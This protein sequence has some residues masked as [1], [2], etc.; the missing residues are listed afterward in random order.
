MHR[1]LSPRSV[2]QRRDLSKVEGHCHTQS[3]AGVVQSR[4]KVF[5]PVQK[6]TEKALG[7]SLSG[8]VG[9]DGIFIPPVP[10]ELMQGLPNCYSYWPLCAGHVDWTTFVDFTNVAAAGEQLGW[11]KLFYGP[12]SLLEEF[13]DTKCS[14]QAV[15]SCHGPLQR[16]VTARYGTTVPQNL[17]ASDAVSWRIR[18]TRLE[19]YS[20]REKSLQRDFASSRCEK[21]SRGGL[22]PYGDEDLSVLYW[23][24][25]H[26]RSGA[27]F[28]DWYLDYSRPRTGPS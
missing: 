16:R 10:G 7:H 4:F 25:R 6:C 2:S 17:H 14:D 13:G 1:S 15:E 20:C 18:G 3:C 12:Q 27:A 24:A 21:V 23:D 22:P 28:F 8:D 19:H 9:S 5:K 26:A 11:R